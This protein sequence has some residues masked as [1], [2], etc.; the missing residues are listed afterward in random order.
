MKNQPAELTGTDAQIEWAER[1]RAQK[2]TEIQD[3]ETEQNLTMRGMDT[4]L[5]IKIDAEGIIAK[6]HGE[7]ESLFVTQ[8]QASFWINCRNMKGYQIINKYTGEYRI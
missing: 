7:V 3:W 2:Y 8:S 1:I 6:V 4:D 5:Q